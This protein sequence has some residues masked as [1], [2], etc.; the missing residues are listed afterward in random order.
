MGHHPARKAFKTETAAVAPSRSLPPQPNADIDPHPRPLDPKTRGL[1]EARFG[2]DFGKVRVHTDARAN[3]SAA[4]M[5]AQAFTRGWSVSFAE[6]RYAP[7]T[8]EGRRLLAH[9]LTHV[10]QQARGA[11]SAP[12]SEATLEAEASANAEA[13]RLGRPALV[14]GQAPRGQPQF[15]RPAPKP[16]PKPARVPASNFKFGDVKLHGQASLDVRSHG[17]LLPGPDQAHI[18]VRDDGLLGYDPGYTTPEDP[19][20]W[21]RL[22]FVVDNGQADI[23][24]VTSTQSFN[25]KEL[26]GDTEQIVPTTLIGHQA[27]GLT[28]QRKSRYLAIYPMSTLRLLEE[29]AVVSADDGRDQIF[30]ETGEKGRGTLDSN[31]L[32]HEFYGH[33]WLALQGVPFV[34]PPGLEE[35]RKTAESRG[36]KLTTHQLAIVSLR[37][38]LKGTLT[39]KHNVRDPFGRPFTGTVREYIDRYA[40]ASIGALESPTQNVGEAKL[41]E[42][43]ASL[44]RALLAPG[45]LVRH[46]DGAPEIS[47]AAGLQWE[48]VSNNYE[49]LGQAPGAT[50]A[51]WT[52]DKLKAELLELYRT[53]DATRQSVFLEILVLIS[54]EY[55]PGGKFR[56]RQLASEL[57]TEIRLLPPTPSKPDAGPR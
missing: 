56:H 5:G 13:V 49:A 11:G 6:G 16:S 50:P 3:E 39:E 37:E 18:A 23:F 42:A 26:S 29:P 2:W 48:I 7:G 30:Y 35:A 44:R 19:F 31:A 22:K 33:Y 45:G 41:Q 57:K 52:P 32:A 12:A 25:V 20:R 51:G 54:T 24:A 15:D 36:Q 21:E 1:M 17:V 34:H 43:L 14:A 38:R 9:E 28:V 46:A 4:A 47:D 10:V 27:S 40:G 55:K 8:T 53:L